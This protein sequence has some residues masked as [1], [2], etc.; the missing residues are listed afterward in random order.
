M[1]PI[2]FTRKKNPAMMNSTASS[3][4]SFTAKNSSCALHQEMNPETGLFSNSDM[5]YFLLL[6][7]SD[8]Y[9]LTSNFSI[10]SP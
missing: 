4:E 3:R 7:P 10:M 1:S 5:T 6:V 8:S 2:D 9:F